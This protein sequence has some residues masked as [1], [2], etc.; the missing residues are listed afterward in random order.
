MRQ[1]CARGTMQLDTLASNGFSFCL[2]SV[3]AIVPA[4]SCCSSSGKLLPHQQH[5]WWKACG[6]PFIWSYR[7]EGSIGLLSHP[8][9]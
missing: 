3:S 5:L 4:A 8:F 1:A 9:R 2:S 7:L 6:S